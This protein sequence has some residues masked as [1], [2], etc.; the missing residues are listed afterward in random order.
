MTVDHLAPALGDRRRAELHASCERAA[1]PGRMLAT[2]V[3]FPDAEPREI[4]ALPNI[5]EEHFALRREG[6]EEGPVALGIHEYAVEAAG[7]GRV[8]KHTHVFGS[9]ASTRLPR[10]IEIGTCS[11]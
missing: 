2:V 7:S 5:T 3:L 10:P 9:A 6:K 1:I 4:G 8:R 11:E